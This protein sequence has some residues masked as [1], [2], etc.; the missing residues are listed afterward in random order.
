MGGVRVSGPRFYLRCEGLDSRLRGND[1]RE[2]APFTVTPAKAGVHRTASLKPA[3]SLPSDG[4]TVPLFR[5]DI[6]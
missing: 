2:K 1:G 4:F 6:W 3:L 5:P